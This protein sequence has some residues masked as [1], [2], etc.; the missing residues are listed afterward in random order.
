M[1]VFLLKLSVLGENEERTSITKLLCMTA[2]GAFKQVTLQKPSVPWGWRNRA[3]GACVT[4]RLH[5]EISKPTPNLP[6]FEAPPAGQ[7]SFQG[8]L[9]GSVRLI[10]RELR[11]AVVLTRKIW[12]RRH[13][14]PLCA[15]AAALWRLLRCK[16][17][18]RPFSP[19]P[20]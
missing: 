8:G 7:L 17:Q 11:Q 18:T 9:L 2:S 6:G 16:L 10:P 20:S 5:E 3:E 12:K 19:A 1:F 15:R 13:Q 14:A 4:L